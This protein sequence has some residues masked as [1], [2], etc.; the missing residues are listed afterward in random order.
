MCIFANQRPVCRGGIHAAFLWCRRLACT[1]PRSS[2]SAA[3][4]AAPQWCFF[5]G[6]ARAGSGSVFS[7]AVTRISCPKQK[8]IFESRWRALNPPAA[9]ICG[10]GRGSPAIGH[11]LATVRHDARWAS[12]RT[13]LQRIGRGFCPR[14]S[15][16]LSQYLNIAAIPP[17]LSSFFLASPSTTST[18]PPISSTDWLRRSTHCGSG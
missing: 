9:A 14:E 13:R 1:I 8:T 16:D 11:S 12:V 18:R 15:Y 17:G 10:R 4:T 3:E 6:R 2:K 5:R 7:F